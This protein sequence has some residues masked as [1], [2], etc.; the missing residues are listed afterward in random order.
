MY[1]VLIK[2]DIAITIMQDFSVVSKRS[3]QND[4]TTIALHCIDSFYS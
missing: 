1:L 3:H 4:A 2:F